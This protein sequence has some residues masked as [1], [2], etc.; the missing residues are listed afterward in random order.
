MS[1]NILLDYEKTAFRNKNEKIR[2]S[3]TTNL[4][5]VCVVIGWLY[6]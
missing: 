5:Q 2:E 4:E 6:F 3:S 1:N